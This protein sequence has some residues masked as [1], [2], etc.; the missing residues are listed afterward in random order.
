VLKAMLREYTR[1]EYLE[2]VQW[3]RTARRDISITTDIIVGFPGESEAEFEETMTLLQAVG[4]DSLFSFKYSPRPNTPAVQYPDSLPDE[5]K[6]RRLARLQELQRE[7][8]TERNARHLGQTLEA[9]VEGRNE[10]RRQ[11]IGRTSQN[12]VVNFTADP[13]ANLQPGDY[14]KVKVDATFPNSLRGQLV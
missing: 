12:K 11:W 6:G 1:E 3:M 4:Y 2:R 14:V 10:Q 5:E 13:T 7:I 8:S 9:M